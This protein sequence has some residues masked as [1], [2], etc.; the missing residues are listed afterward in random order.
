MNRR[1]FVKIGLSLPVLS[2]APVRVLA[3]SEDQGHRAYRPGERISP[4]VFVQDK[5][6]NAQKILAL[7]QEGGA[8]VNVLYIYGGGAYKRKSKLGELWCRDSFEDLYVLRYLHEKYESR[9]VRLIPV[10]C[11]PVYASRYYGFK[12]RVFLD[13]PDDSPTFQQAAKDFIASTE[14]AVARRYVPVETYYDLRYRLLFNRRR[15]L[16][17][18]PGYGPVYSWQG[19]FRSDRE[20]QKYGTPTIWLL[21][22]RGTILRPPFHGNLYHAEPFHIEYTVLDLDR[23]VQQYL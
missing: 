6:L 20:T 10:A 15:D 22:A 16:K 3:A 7:C 18:G 11:P 14:K 17:P 21:D 5:S 1:T 19:K 12:P 23:A 13:E 8:P 2:L 9:K 4:E